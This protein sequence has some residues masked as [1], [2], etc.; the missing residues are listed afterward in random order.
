[1]RLVSRAGLFVVCGASALA[2]LTMVGSGSASA[3][4]SQGSAPRP[5]GFGRCVVVTE[6]G[7]ANG[8]ATAAPIF[9]SANT[10]FL[11][12]GPDLAHWLGDSGL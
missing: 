3:L 1:M 7:L 12:P 10:Y 4:G 6:T 2:S 5:E 11:C 8:L 9:R